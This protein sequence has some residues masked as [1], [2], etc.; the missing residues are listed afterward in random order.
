[1]MSMQEFD[2]LFGPLSD[3]VSPIH[4][5]CPSTSFVHKM[6]KECKPHILS[7][8]R[9]MTQVFT[10]EKLIEYLEIPSD[11]TTTITTT[12]ADTASVDVPTPMTRKQE[13]LPYANQ[14]FK[15]FEKIVSESTI[16]L[17]DHVVRLDNYEIHDDVERAYRKKLISKVESLLSRVDKVK[18]R[19]VQSPNQLR[20]QKMEQE[21]NHVVINE[22]Q[23]VL[24]TVTSSVQNSKQALMA[25]M[26]DLASLELVEDHEAEQEQHE[27]LKTMVHEMLNRLDVIDSTIQEV[28]SHQ[29]PVSEEKVCERK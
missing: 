19:L 26:L 18:Q 11:D 29:A 20:M 6:E 10:D 22:L 3:L 15:T 13:L 27:R 5:T 16:L 2:S 8:V 25:M 4:T 12:S 1:M 28:V 17:E 9:F 14:F 21:F 24:S 23:P 7:L